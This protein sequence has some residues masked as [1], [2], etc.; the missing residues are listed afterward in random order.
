MTWT[1]EEFCQGRKIF[2]GKIEVGRWKRRTNREIHGLFKETNLI[3]IVIAQRVR[4]IGDIMR[5]EDYR[6][7]KMVLIHEVGGRKRLRRP[8]QRW[9]KEVEDDIRKLNIG[10]W[11]KKSEI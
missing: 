7:P 9:K 5:M 8:R 4:W 1:K 11:K 10:N 3:G 2:G 6:K